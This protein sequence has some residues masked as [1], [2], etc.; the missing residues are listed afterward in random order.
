M[1]KI[2]PVLHHDLKDTKSILEKKMDYG[3]SGIGNM[4][5]HMMSQYQ[6]NSLHR[7]DGETLVDV[8]HKRNQS[9]SKTRKLQDSSGKGEKPRGESNSR[10]R[11]GDSLEN[12]NLEELTHS[13]HHMNGAGDQPK[14]T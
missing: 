8:T 13:D 1:T 4:F 3:F 7:A 11:S 12:E 10:R 5:D 14:V 6:G 2:I 9:S